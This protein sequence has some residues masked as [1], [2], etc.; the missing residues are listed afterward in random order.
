MK[1]YEGAR[2]N[3]SIYESN[4]YMVL[5]FTKLEYRKELEFPKLEFCMTFFN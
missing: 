4:S 3:I 1:V 5:E 2:S